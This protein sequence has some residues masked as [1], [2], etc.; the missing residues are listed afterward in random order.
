VSEGGKSIRAS[1]HSAQ[2]VNIGRGGKKKNVKGGRTG[3]K[4]SGRNSLINQLKERADGGW[5]QR[6]GD[7]AVVERESGREI[8]RA[9]K[10]RSIV[11]G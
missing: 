5:Q 8:V 10:K 1:R 3:I 6:D 9:G 4:V 7:D 11:Q 2:L